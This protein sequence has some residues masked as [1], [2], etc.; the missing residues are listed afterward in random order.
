[1]RALIIEHEPF[2][3]G[4]C[5]IGAYLPER[6][7]EPVS[8]LVTTDM[9]RPNDARPFP[10]LKGFDLLVVM[11]SIRSLAAR[12]EI[13]SWIGAEL[14]LIAA[15]HGDGVPILG[16]CFG[17][18][19]LAEALGGTVEVAPETEIGWYDLSPAPGVENPVGSG[20]WMEWHHDRFTAPPGAELLAVTPGAEQLFRIGRSVGTQF[21]PEVNAA[22]VEAWLTSAPADYLAE[23]GVDVAAQSA[24]ARSNE[25]ANIAQCRRL[26]DWFLDE[27]AGI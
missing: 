22:H 6:G 1:M 18:Q 5:E 16:V 26:V 20:P 25:A 8:H 3:A 24:A 19:L 2:A 13:R 10:S 11:G 14:D 27:V 17:G 23:H 7:I 15:A 9:D 12:E 4:S 21:H